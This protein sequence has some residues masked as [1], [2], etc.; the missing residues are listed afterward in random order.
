MLGVC[1]G[2]QI[3]AEVAG[4][5][6]VRSASPMHGK[7]CEVL[8][9]GRS[10][11]FKNIPSPFVAGRYHSLTVE[12]KTIPYPF[13]VTATSQDGLVMAVQH[14]SLPVFGVQFHPESVLTEHG[15][16]LLYNFLSIA[17]LQPFSPDRLRIFA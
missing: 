7:S 17:G 15:Y 3:I 1:L 10:T 9:D 4:S 6:V 13:R 16:Q 8:H 5:T 12:P 11:L 14:V 2:H